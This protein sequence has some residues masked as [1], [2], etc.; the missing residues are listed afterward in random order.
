MYKPLKTLAA[1]IAVASLP[2]SI[3]AAPYSQLI[4]FGDSLSDTGQFIDQQNPTSPSGVRFTNRTG[5]G[6][7]APAPYGQV[8]TQILADQLGLQALPSTPFR[9]IGVHPAGTNY[10]VGGYRTDQIRDSIT[11]TSV[12]VPPP[13]NTPPLASRPGYLAEFGSADRNALYYINGGGNNVIQGLM[14]D[15]ATATASAS[16]LVAGVAALQ[17]A[18]ARYIVVSDLPDVGN[19]PLGLISGQRASMSA[20]TAVFNQEL[21]R[22]LTELGG[23]ILRLNFND[24]LSEVYADLGAFGFDASITQINTCFDDGTGGSSGCG[25]LANSSWAINGAT[26]NANRL[27]FNDGVH[28]TEAVHRISGDYMY[29]VL[30]APAEISLLPEMGLA[31]LTSHQQHLQSQWQTQRGNWQETGKWNGF[32]AGGVMRNDF[33]RGQV[34]P[35]TDGKGTQ[36]TLG[37]SYRMDDNWRLGLALGLQRQELDTDSKSNY[38]MDSYLLT[39]FAQYQRERAWADASLSYGHLDYSDLKRQF[40]LGITQRAEKGDTDGSLL[41]FSARVGYD[42]ANPGTGWQVSPFI[43]ADIAKVDVDGY[44]E[45]GTRSTALFYGDQQRDS[46]R[47]GLGVQMKRQLN[48]QTAWHAELATEREMKDDTSHVRTGLVSRSG[49]SA[50]LPGY[51]PEKSNLTGAVGITHDLGNELQ[52]GASYHFRGTDDR[53]HGLNLSLGWNW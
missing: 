25:P 32:V 46:Q 19:T 51:M 18:G 21:D 45:A 2:M 49:N 14:T 42:L 22:Q 26:P 4:I 10:A 39:G 34:V 23:S 27:I 50:S 1:A 41:A 43:S 44:R 33:K 53:Q 30:S 35:S 38:E 36:L 8:S 6:Y 3:S 28:P 17:Q 13:G 15:F 24:L 52:V 16:E 47:L 29:S 12:T 9:A 11:T 37:S 5:P 40:A 48:Q 31:S 20:I 7:L